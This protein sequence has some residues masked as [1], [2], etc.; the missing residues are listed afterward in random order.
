MS[1]PHNAPH[2]YSSYYAHNLSNLT[3]INRGNVAELR[4][5]FLISIG[6]MN[7]TNQ[8]G[9]PPTLESTPVVNEGVMYV[10]NGWGQVLKFDLRS[11]TRAQPLWIHDPQLEA[12]QTMRGSVALLGNYVYHNTGSGNPRLIKVN[13]DT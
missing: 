7:T 10:Q 4:A 13:A 12:G 9:T 1:Y 6:G 5:K 8:T 11:G 2:P 3:H